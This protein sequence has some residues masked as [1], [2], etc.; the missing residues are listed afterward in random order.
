MTISSQIEQFSGASPQATDIEESRA[1]QQFITMK[2]RGAVLMTGLQ[3]R[4]SD[5]TM[6]DPV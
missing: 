5:K 1:A 3:N 4:D 6:G 2:A